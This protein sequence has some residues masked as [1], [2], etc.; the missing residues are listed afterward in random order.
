MSPKLAR[1]EREGPANW[2][3]L[4][5]GGRNGLSAASGP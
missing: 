4:I 5:D 3:S 2:Q 1:I